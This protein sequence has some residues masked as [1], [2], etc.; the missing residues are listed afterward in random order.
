MCSTVSVVLSCIHFLIDQRSIG[1]RSGGKHIYY[2]DYTESTMILVI[3]SGCWFGLQK[4]VQMAPNFLAV[5][6]WGSTMK[7][8]MVVLL[9]CQ[10]KLFTNNSRYTYQNFDCTSCVNGLKDSELSPSTIDV[11]KCPLYKYQG[12]KTWHRVYQRSSKTNSH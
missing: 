8:T 7:Q 9:P 10:T 11:Y 1:C 3:Q 4:N 12:H 2:M 6:I 5:Y